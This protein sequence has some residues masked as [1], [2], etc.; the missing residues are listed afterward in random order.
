MVVY[1]LKNI[2][3]FLSF[4]FP[5]LPY[6]KD[7]LAPHLSLEAVEIHF[8]R[9]HHSYLMKLNDLCQNTPF[10]K[11][12]LETVIKN[13]SGAIFN[14]AAQF[15]NHNIFWQSLSPNGGGEPVG[16]LLQALNKNFGSVEKFKE[17]FMK[18]A[19]SLFGSGWVWLVQGKKDELEIIC[20]SNADTPIIQGKKPLLTLDLWEHSYYIDYRSARPAYI[21]AFWS[22]VNWSF[23]HH[24]LKTNIHS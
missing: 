14:N 19:G 16:E 3:V 4:I 2:G 7:A 1:L 9:H 5:P 10:A 15:Y 6:R 24:N 23:A 18:E 13:S 21:N 17:L 8:D 11:M 22:L 20:T 12:D